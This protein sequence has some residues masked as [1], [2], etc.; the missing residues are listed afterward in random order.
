MELDT[1]K[2]M[3]A[4][5]RAR[6]E[7]I[8]HSKT[9]KRELS[10]DLAKGQKIGRD[11]QRDFAKAAGPLADSVVKAAGPLAESVVKAAKPLASFSRDVAKAAAPL[12]DDAVALGAAA[13]AAA[14][15]YGRTVKPG[16]AGKWAVSVAKR[17][18]VILGLSVLGLA[19]A[20][21]FALTR[22]T[23]SA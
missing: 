20:T 7:V 5:K 10:R 1:D 3:K 15:E 2:A 11:F 13:I 19:G 18:P 14:I 12:A 6:K 23:P 4:G 8:A 17:N 21:I 9:L 16:T 22:R